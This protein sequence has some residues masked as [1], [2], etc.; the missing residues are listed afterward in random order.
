[1]ATRNRTA[2]AS[3]K[4]VQAE[5]LA[6]NLPD[7]L[8]AVSPEGTILFWNTQAERTFG[9][10]SREALGRDVTDLIVA[11]ER[12]EEVQRLTQLTLESGYAACESV[13]RRKDGSV[14]YIDVSLAVVRNAEG[15]VDFLTMIGRDIT[16]RVY[17]R[18]AEILGGK[19]RGLLESAPD[20]M[21]IVNR[22]GRIVLVNSQTEKLF[23]YKREELLGQL[24]E[25][26][27]P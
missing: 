10:T 1:M 5:N 6:D 9:H 11:P 20:A 24:V 25:V 19:F 17:L 26:L 18:E 2:L 22:D 14:I 21:V 27:L 3:P 13:G 16:Q 23:G 12:V 15:H 4:P 8:I 7:A